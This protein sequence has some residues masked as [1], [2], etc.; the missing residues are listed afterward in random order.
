[1]IQEYNNIYYSLQLIGKVDREEKLYFDL[2]IKLSDA[3]KATYFNL[4]IIL[5]DINDNAPLFQETI[6][7]GNIRFYKFYVPENQLRLNFAHINCLDLDEGINS[8][9]EFRILDENNPEFVKSADSLNPNYLFY[10]NSDNGSLSLRGELDREQR[11]FYLFTIRVCDKPGLCAEILV[12]IAILD[13]ND[14][15]PVFAQNV[16]QF[17]LDENK[18]A[19][20]IIGNIKAQ[21]PDLNPR[22]S[23]TIEPS[24]FNRYF[25]IDQENGNLMT[26]I[27][28]DAEDPSLSAVLVN[29]SFNFRVL[30]KDAVLQTRNLDSMSKMNVSIYLNDLNDNLPE[31]L[32]LEKIIL[33]DL[34]KNLSLLKIF[35]CQ[36]KDRELRNRN[37]SLFKIN[38]IRR[39]S[40]QFV[41]EIVK[42]QVD[43]NET[44]FFLDWVLRNEIKPLAKLN[45]RSVFSLEN[46]IKLNQA[47]LILTQGA[48]LNWGVYNFS[49]LIQDSSNFKTEF[50]IKLFVFNSLNNNSLGFNLSQMEVLGDLVESWWDKN[51]NLIK[52]RKNSDDN[53]DDLDG[54][55]QEFYRL[56]SSARFNLNRNNS[57]VNLANMFLF[58]K[59][60]NSILVV[61][62]AFCVLAIL[63]IGFISYKQFQAS[64]NKE[65]K[66]RKNRNTLINVNQLK[67]EDSSLDSTGSI[68]ISDYLNDKQSTKDLSTSPRSKFRSLVRKSFK[69]K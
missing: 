27:S 56:Y 41:N 57:L 5:I 4:R 11:E 25:L 58:N 2:K 8:Q 21:D 53:G 52:K 62:S 10:I 16:A 39:L 31:V 43:S 36:D 15:Q 13:E 67:K 22:T 30:V 20:F 37:N 19:N 1:M 9:L 14:N 47:E 69:S 26:R 42:N 24:E 33:L 60:S 49:I 59:A 66:Y 40:W 32:S 3:S 6:S 35:N 48:K 29:N 44:R 61:I 7:N 63:L 65:K 68:N 38:F 34:S 18:P 17:I 23:Y 50:S 12:E 54:I 46:K 55:G 64:G 28:L 45:L 51:Y